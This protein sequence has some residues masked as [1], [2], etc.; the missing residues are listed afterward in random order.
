VA[1]AV[2]DRRGWDETCVDILDTPPVTRTY[3]GAIAHAI[4]H[5]MHHRAQLLY[6]LKGL[7]LRDLPEGDVLSWES[8]VT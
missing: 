3:G 5:S 8:Q 7:G 1:R 6:M 4:T 2:S